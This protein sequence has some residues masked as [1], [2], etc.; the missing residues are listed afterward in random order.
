M[1]VVVSVVAE[2]AVVV[3]EIFVCVMLLFVVEAYVVVPV[4]DVT[5]VAVGNVCVP[6]E[7]VEIVV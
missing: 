2:V 5:D 4:L 6:V 3:S 1:N 7:R